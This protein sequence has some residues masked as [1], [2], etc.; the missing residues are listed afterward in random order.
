MKVGFCLTIIAIVLVISNFSYGQENLMKNGGFEDGVLA[1]WST[2]N[3]G[4]KTEIVASGAIEGKYYLKVITIKGAN[5]WDAGLQHN[6]G[7]YTFQKGK[8]YT[9]A[10]FLRSPNK[11]QINFKPELGVNPWTGYGEKSFTMTEDWAEYYVTTPVFDSDVNPGTITF[12]IA[13]DAGEFHIDG[14]RF[15]EGDY[16]APPE[17]K[18]SSVES[19]NKLATVWGKLKA[20]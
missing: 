3:D 18:P 19:K 16:V 17:I 7:N 13:Y 9:L 11:L 15:F 2:Y 12:H 10:A 1:P 8:K 20:E 4:V 14:A 5:F 6:A